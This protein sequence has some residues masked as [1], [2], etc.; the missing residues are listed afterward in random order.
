MNNET[1]N[2]VD[3][4]AAYTQNAYL[5]VLTYYIILVLSLRCKNL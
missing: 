2:L 5:D 4:I 1:I 3:M